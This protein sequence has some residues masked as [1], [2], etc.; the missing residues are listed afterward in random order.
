MREHKKHKTELIRSL[1]TRT[2][3]ALRQIS[4]SINEIK[5]EFNR[6]EWVL[7][8]MPHTFNVA[9]ELFESDKSVLI[10]LSGGYISGYN[11]VFDEPVI[12]HIIKMCDDIRWVFYVHIP[13]FSSFVKY[14]T[15]VYSRIKLRG[16]LKLNVKGLNGMYTIKHGEYVTV[17]ATSVLDV[18]YVQSNK[19][20]RA[21]IIRLE[22]PIQQ[23]SEHLNKYNHYI[24][25]IAQ[26]MQSQIRKSRLLVGH[27]EQ[28]IT[29]YSDYIK[30]DINCK[31]CSTRLEAKTRYIKYAFAMPIDV[32]GPNNFKVSTE[33]LVYLYVH[34]TYVLFEWDIYHYYKLREHIPYIT[35]HISKL[36]VH[37]LSE[38]GISK[39]IIDK[40]RRKNG[41]FVEGKE[42]SFDEPHNTIPVN[43]GVLAIPI[44]KRVKIHIANKNDIVQTDDDEI[45]DVSTLESSDIVDIDELNLTIIDCSS[46][47]TK[48][49][50]LEH[51][52]P[53]ELGLYWMAFMQY[54]L[55]L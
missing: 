22:V 50:N 17:E 15:I 33:L 44:P 40:C 45:E 43:L 16:Q 39:N 29:A 32:Y 47:G 51:S 34:S 21:N 1:D 20:T 36:I 12:Y 38:L 41:M 49:T 25:H 19:D 3:E 27:L 5:K 30:D 13:E 46:K 26:Y 8:Y 2:K 23:L 28:H 35:Q 4:E 42:I 10:N 6:T 53:C 14:Q 11:V 54:R 48:I 7:Y 18:L 24:R 52:R 31:T 9:R 55:P 37:M